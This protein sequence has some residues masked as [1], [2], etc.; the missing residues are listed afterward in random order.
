MFQYEDGQIEMLSKRNGLA[1]F[2]KSLSFAFFLNP[3]G[4]KLVLLSKINKPT[5][6]GKKTPLL[7]LQQH[8]ML[9]KKLK[10]LFATS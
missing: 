10:E 6:L 9:L 4:E 1:F 8:Q 2:Q 3:S 7:H 5:I